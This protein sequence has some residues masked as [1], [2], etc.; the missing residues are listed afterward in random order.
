M[1]KE[2]VSVSDAMT[3]YFIGL[4]AGYTMRWNLCRRFMAE[5]LSFVRELGFHRAGRVSPTARAL[6]INRFPVNEKGFVEEEMGK[7]VFWV[8]FLGIRCVP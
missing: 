6:G 4:S 3:S 2:Q 8:L 7:R 1:E 5:A